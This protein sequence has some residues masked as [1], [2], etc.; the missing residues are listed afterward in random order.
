MIVKVFRVDVRH[1]ANKHNRTRARQ[2]RDSNTNLMDVSVLFYFIF[3]VFCSASTESIMPAPQRTVFGGKKH[4]IAQKRTKAHRKSLKRFMSP[5]VLA[6]VHLC[7]THS[8]R[9]LTHSLCRTPVHRRH[10]PMCMQNRFAYFSEI[11][12]RRSSRAVTFC[13]E[14][15]FAVAC[16]AERY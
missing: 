11:H 8:F 15:S 4:E 6:V 3:S 2:N 1:K 14:Q 13:L 16:T 7:A 12:S 5:N 9:S 10:T